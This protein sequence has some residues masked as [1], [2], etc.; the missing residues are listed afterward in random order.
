MAAK[1]KDN[2]ELYRNIASKC[3]YQ[4]Y[5]SAEFPQQ[6][7]Y[8]QD[9]LEKINFSISNRKIFDY[10]HRAQYLYECMILYLD[11]AKF[12]DE[13]K[14]KC[15][16][17]FSDVSNQVYR[18]VDQFLRDYELPAVSIKHC[19]PFSYFYIDTLN[20]CIIQLTATFSIVIR[21]VQSGIKKIWENY[22]DKVYP[23]FF[24]S[25]YYRDVFDQDYLFGEMDFKTPYYYG[26]KEDFER[27]IKQINSK[28][29]TIVERSSDL[30]TLNRNCEEPTVTEIENS[31]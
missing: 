14:Q 15:I 20:N 8:S 7:Y 29:S 2:Y 21:C 24:D 3:L 28:T 19:R 25:S 4:L 12:S 17:T 11:L 6:M 18:V 10:Y 27:L 23:D 5:N 9:Y 26:K 31:I 1:G 16:D 22:K 13:E 30:Q